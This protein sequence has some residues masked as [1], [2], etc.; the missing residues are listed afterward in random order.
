M[1]QAMDTFCEGQDGNAC[2]VGPETPCTRT[3]TGLRGVKF[4]LCDACYREAQRDME[5]EW[6]ND[7]REMER[8]GYF[9]EQEGGGHE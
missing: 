8:E 7:T 3:M 1:T 4:P 9:C 6:Q 5:R 2:V